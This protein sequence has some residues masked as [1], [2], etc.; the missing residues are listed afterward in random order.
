VDGQETLQ[1]IGE[2]MRKHVTNW[3]E[4]KKVSTAIALIDKT[5]AA[6]RNPPKHDFWGAGEADCPREIKAGNGEL[7]T[8]RCKRCGLDNPRDDRCLST[9]DAPAEGWEALQKAAHQFRFYERE[10]RAKVQHFK[11]DE[12]YENARLASNAAALKKAEVNR[13]MAEMCEKALRT[14]MSVN[15]RG[16]SDATT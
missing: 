6:A 4:P 13:E 5:L 12:F 7:H 1:A 16:A 9:A 10:H 2:M 8:L 14:P 3:P 15:P 11:G